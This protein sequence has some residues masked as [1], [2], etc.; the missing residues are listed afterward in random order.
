MKIAVV[1]ASG[2]TGRE[3][4]RVAAAAGHEV[5]AV[6]RDPSRLPDPPGEFR[7]ADASDVAALAAAFAGVEAV[8]SC[9]G[10]VP[11]ESAHVLRDGVTAVLAAMDRAGVRR[12]VAISA[13]GWVVDG[14]DPLSRYV[15]KPIL[16]RALAT[17][18]A[19]LEAM[20][21]VIRASHVDWTIMRPPRLQD[22]PGTGRYQARRDGNVRW[23][24]TIARPDLALAM[25]DA[26]T[27]RTAVGQAISVAA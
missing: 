19:D 7:V 25:L 26:V 15:A 3:L 9:L 4:V 21:Q 2:R 11:G 27:D 17:T 18:N 24:W 20:E 23:A 10:P 6:V 14:D 13:S 12:L 1:G 16:K 5:V 22:R 8:A